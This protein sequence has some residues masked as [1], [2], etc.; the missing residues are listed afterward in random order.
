MDSDRR[1]S[2]PGAYISGLS[3]GMGSHTPDRLS[4][5]NPMAS[6]LAAAAAAN[7]GSG[8]SS[9][10]MGSGVGSAGPMRDSSG[11]GRGSGP[12]T[13]RPNLSDKDSRGHAGGMV[14]T[15]AAAAAAAAGHPVP[16][17]IVAPENERNRAVGTPDY[18]APELLLGTGHGPEVDW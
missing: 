3:M 6:S 16:G 13:L 11:Q 9:G 5:L 2:L 12:R 14:A 17:R 15:A 7:L 4:P 8:P 18:L 10:N 1:L